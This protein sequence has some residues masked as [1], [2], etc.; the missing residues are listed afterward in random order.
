MGMLALTG[1]GVRIATALLATILEV[2]WRGWSFLD[3]TLIP[4]QLTY[5]WF[6]TS[7]GLNLGLRLGHPRPSIRRLR[8]SLRTLIVRVAYAGLIF[9]LGPASSIAGRF[10]PASHRIYL[11]K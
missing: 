10:H 5:P 6:C 9:G 11:I 4:A 7:A 8:V 2:A 1:F 3:V